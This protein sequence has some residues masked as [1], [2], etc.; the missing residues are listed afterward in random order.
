MQH[1]A[2]FPLQ[3][4]P[5]AASAWTVLDTAFG[6][7]TAFLATCQQWRDNP[8][9]AVML[10]YV[11]VLST[12]APA[13]WPPELGGH[14]DGLGAGFHRITFDGGHIS[15]TLCIGPLQAMLSEQSM[16]ADLVFLSGADKAWDKWS[17]KALA[18]QCR[19]D[20]R[21]VMSGANSLPAGA[22]EEAGFRAQAD[23]PRNAVPKY[24]FDPRWNL[25][26]SRKP[27][28]AA[29]TPGH[30]AVIG[31]G[32]AG[33]SVAHA[34]AL[35]GW[36]VSVLDR[37]AAAAGGAS[38]LPVGLVVPHVS[39][40]D[41]PRSR[42]SRSGTRLMLA[43][44]RQLLTDGSDWS[45]T[46]VLEKRAL[47]ERDLWHPMAGWIKPAHIVNAWL[48][49]PAIRFL[50]HSDVAC[51][52]SEGTQWALKTAQGATLATA[53][54]IVL[55]NAYACGALGTSHGLD[56]E[57][58]EVHGLLSHGAMPGDTAS[59][60]V[61]GF[62]DVPVNGHGSFLSGIP[63]AGG[64]QWFAGSTFEADA[65][66]HADS[67][68]G[69][70]A[71]FERLRKLLPAAAAPLQDAFLQGH[72]A[73][74][75][76]TRCVTHDRLPLVGPIQTTGPHTLWISAGMGA[77]GLS[78]SALCAELL[79]AQMGGEPL[80]VESSLVR[81]VHALRPRR[82]RLDFLERRHDL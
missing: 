61:H 21:V 9:R 2:T 49:H 8:Q 51:I 45:H 63:T 50:G 46:G 3:P 80:P 52:E 39:V 20:A 36:R 71:N 73:A 11:G 23:L 40:D 76:G 56:A 77:R 47:P 24:T 79:A 15:L 6:S 78:L 1:K 13:V 81:N 66:R 22:L 31:A 42:L 44:A 4:D 60:G 69:H 57:L 28:I 70:Q 67:Q 72:V 5:A 10:H 41:S 48:Q 53:D 7:G 55:A 37:H 26:T 29:A 27:S 19:R 35:R 16:R 30:C 34:L 43:H 17:I 12:P 54:H 62:P 65:L 58:Q 64:P 18:R 75:T 38:G 82:K 32:L 33:A 14:C 74:W 25:S 68:A 59:P